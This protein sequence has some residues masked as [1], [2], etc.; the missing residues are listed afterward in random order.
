MLDK[1][2]VAP[3]FQ[4][5]S[6]NADRDIR[7][8]HRRIDSTDIY[9]VTNHQRRSEEIVA[10]F[11]VEGKLPEFWDAVTG[12]ITP[13]IAYEAANGRVRVPIRLEPSGSVFVVFRGPA[14]N[15]ALRSIARD[16]QPVVTTVDF[17]ATPSAPY[18]EITNNFT[19]SVWVKPEIE[20]SGA[21]GFG[22]GGF[23]QEATQGMAGAN[24][25]SFVIHPPEGDTL[26]GEGH[27]A[28]GFTAGRDGVVVY[29]RARNLFAP[30]LAAPQPMS[31]WNHVAL[32]YRD[33]EPS[34]YFNGKLG[35]TG[36][37]TG[38]IV[39]PG[40]GSPDANVRFVHFEGDMTTPALSA[41]PLGEERIRHL[42]AA[43][44]DPEAPAAVE[45]SP[46]APGLLIWQNGEYLLRDTAGRSTP[47]RVSG[48]PDPVV[49]R[50]SWRVTFPP[51][52]GAPAEVTLPQLISLDQHTEPGVKY[53]SGTA[54]YHNTFTVP[55]GAMGG[56]RH[57]FL[58]LG[59]VEV[60]AEVL[61]NG[62]NLGALWKPPYLVDA[63]DA[64]RAGDNT[65]EVRVTNLWPNRLIGDEQLPEEYAFGPAN[66]PA[67]G[68]GGGNAANAI[69]EIPKWFVEGKPKPPGS[70]IT[71]TTWR[72]WRKDSALLA[73]GLLGPVQL[74]FAVRRP[75]VA[76][77][78]EA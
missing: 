44:P 13:A 18:R 16:G 10:S 61:V 34:L 26:Y 21:G 32:V 3:D 35:K 46:G 2:R 5:T 1:L 68:G 63:S 64:L 58:D 12:D 54:A 76:G 51:N 45:A 28:V 70:R 59:R 22:G 48:L 56:E 50:G 65:L 23:T 38:R 33:G 30:V 52:L 31:G 55:Q 42:A 6:P 17:A 29:E 49:V 62:R 19:I 69:R 40:L 60:L 71:F 37:R 24:A 78:S 74:R 36:K 11:R 25:S 9:F 57:V 14:T 66:P 53:F 43:V 15:R 77:R 8:I 72:H 27:S 73:S 67:G 7:Y 20:L 41:G 75:L 47:M 39:H 4:F